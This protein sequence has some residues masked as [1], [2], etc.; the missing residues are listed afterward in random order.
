MFGTPV[1]YFRAGRYTLGSA[2]GWLPAVE[3]EH[4]P[5]LVAGLPSGV[6]RIQVVVNPP[7]TATVTALLPVKLV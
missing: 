5:Q 7:A 2:N 1:K 6:D 4:N 3:I